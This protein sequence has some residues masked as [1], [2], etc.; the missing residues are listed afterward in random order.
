[1]GIKSVTPVLNVASVPDSLA[2]FE[3]LGWARSFTWNQSGMIEGAADANDAGDA[4][5]CGLCCGDAQVFLCLEG[6]GQQ[7]TPL[8]AAEGQPSTDGSWMS[9]WMESQESFE[10][11]HA[12]VVELGYRVQSPPEDCPWGVR[13]F[14]LRHPDGHVFRISCSTC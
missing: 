1:M 7:G 12:Q 4:D 11:L 14:H 5:F 3:A 13:E 6:Q 8:P 2:W 10:A 9:W